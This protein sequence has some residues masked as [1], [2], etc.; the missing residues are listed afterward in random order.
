MSARLLF[1]SNLFPTA[2]EPYRGLDNATLLHALA[3]DYEIRVISPQPSLPWSR[4]RHEAREGDAVLQPRWVN[5]AYVPKIGGPVNHLL[6][7]GSVGRVFEET[8]RDFRPTVM[9]SSWIY[10]DSCAA[11]RLA[12]GR[13]PVVAIAQG[14]DVHQ[15]LGM[16]GRRGVILRTLPQA[17]AVI[18]RSGELSRILEAAG[19]PAG[20][21]HTVYNGVDL[22][23]F[24]PRDARAARREAGLPVEGRIIL[25]VGNFFAVKNPQLLIQ[26][27]ASMPTVPHLVMAG[28]GPLEVECRGQV[29]RLGIA[30]RV[31][32]AGR[33][34]PPEIARLMNAADVLALPSRNEGVPNVILEAFA[35]GLPIIA[36]RVGGIPEVLDSEALGKLVPEGSMVSTLADALEQQLAK[37]RGT[38]AIRA[39]GER[40]S[41]RAAADAYREILASS[42]L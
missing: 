28:G 14:S 18:T 19:F 31:T 10:A 3:A 11:I 17:S 34:T 41:W 15:Y 24:Q 20:K 23:T 13:V 29:E 32:F 30:E 39:R 40:F 26:A 36:S 6:M 33:K 5:A 9:L 2:A 42:I 22:E 8:M 25:F 4:A 12:A 1:F 37:P 21:L 16:A 35:S 27:V 7:A 38:T